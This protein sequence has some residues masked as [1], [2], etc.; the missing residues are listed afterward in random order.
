[1]PRVLGKERK[2]TGA[3]D[4][5]GLQSGD[6]SGALPGDLLE[7]QD[8][9]HDVD[10]TKRGPTAGGKTKGKGKG[11]DRVWKNSLLPEEKKVLKDFFE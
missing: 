8:G 1:M 9:E 4:H 7:T 6:L 3:G 11:G 2:D 5:K 10:K